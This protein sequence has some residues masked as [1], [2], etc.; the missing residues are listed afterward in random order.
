MRA[1]STL[2]WSQSKIFLVF[3]V[4]N[5]MARGITM[6]YRVNGGFV[7]TG[8]GQIYKKICKTEYLS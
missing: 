1:R 7:F 6:R 2:D 4:K 8:C 3:E 5:R